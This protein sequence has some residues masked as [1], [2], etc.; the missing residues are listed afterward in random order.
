M[1]VAVILAAGDSS[2]MGSPKALLKIGECSFIRQI[3]GMYEKSDVDK[4]I[5]VSQPDATAIHHELE[6]KYIA[7]VPNPDYPKGQLSSVITGVDAA[8]KLH[9]E[10][11][12]IHPVDHPAVGEV[13]VNSLINAYRRDKSLLVIPTYNGERGHPVLFSSELFQELR[14]APL[15]VGAR[16][17]VRKHARSTT[18]IEVGDKGVILDIDTRE[19]YENLRRNLQSTD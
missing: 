5:V 9:A 1:I 16:D 12:L 11:V 10:A 19:D 6:G 17:V 7:V 4:I 18:E 13:V 2:R 14:Q 15:T 3:C 8:E